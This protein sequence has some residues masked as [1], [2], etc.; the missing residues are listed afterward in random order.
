M[1]TIRLDLNSNL[2]YPILSYMATGLP[3]GY[4]FSDY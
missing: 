3:V 2:N 1:H 4:N